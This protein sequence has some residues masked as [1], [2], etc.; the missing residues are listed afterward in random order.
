VKKL[1]RLALAC[2]Y[3]RIPIRRNDISQ[4]V[5]DPGSRQFKYVFDNAQK[6]LRERF[7]MEMV[8]QP[9]KEKVTISQ[10]RGELELL[11]NNSNRFRYTNSW[12]KLP[13]ASKR[14]PHR[15]RPGH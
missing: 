12:L 7:G 3:A 1:V 6:Q 9:S 5:L 14:R 13:N 4:K 2:E 8:E 15:P 11:L 10:K